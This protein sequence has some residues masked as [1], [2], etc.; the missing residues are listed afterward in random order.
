[1]R[2]RSF[3]TAAAFQRH[4]A[5]DDEGRTSPRAYIRRRHEQMHFASITAPAHGH[6]EKCP[7]HQASEIC[8]AR[9]AS[10]DA[11]EIKDVAIVEVAQESRHFNMRLPLTVTAL[12][13]RA[14]AA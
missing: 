9:P 11:L 3:A 1:M 4:S 8:A 10:R 7:R 14:E 13:A 2:C 5:R 6:V 12:G